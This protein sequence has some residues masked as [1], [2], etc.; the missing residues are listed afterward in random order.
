MGMSCSTARLSALVEHARIDCRCKEVVGGSD[1]VDVTRQVQVHLLH[2]DD[3]QGKPR[4]AI[5]L[6]AQLCFLAVLEGGCTE[7]T[8]WQA[9]RSLR[10]G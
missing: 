7:G 4:C 8:H 5:L 6:T 2:W 10:K 1:C 3:L 9:S